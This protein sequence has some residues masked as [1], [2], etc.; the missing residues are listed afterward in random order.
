M[1]IQKQYIL[2]FVPN[3]FVDYIRVYKEWVLLL[4]LCGLKKIIKLNSTFHIII[5]SFSINY[6]VAC[7][8]LE[9]LLQ[10]IDVLFV[11]PSFYIQASS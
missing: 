2:Y 6:T 10:F 3:S 8:V 7:D 5:N 1:Y 9:N 11:S 4:Y